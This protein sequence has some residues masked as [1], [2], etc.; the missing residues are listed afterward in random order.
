LA[1]SQ[2]SE[3]HAY[4][5]IK[6]NLDLLGW[7][8]RNPERSATGQ[9]WTQNEVTHN[10]E[11]RRYL[12]LNKPEN[13]VKV[14]DRVLWVIEAKR[15][16]SQL[17]QAVREAEDY[18]TTLRPSSQVQP[19]FVTG[20]AGNDIDSYLVRSEFWNGTQYVPIT[21]N[22][23]PAT[24]LLALAHLEQILRTGQGKSVIPRLTSGCSWPAPGTSTKSYTKGRLTRISVPA[25]W[26]RSSWRS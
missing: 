12:I 4:A 5:W 17:H 18:A 20:V 19:L 8:I 22:D 25:S 14:T 10:E 7:D 9:V 23:I 11:L 2:D 26:Q 3:V 24:G 15:S 21:L 1:R 6:K 13:I 16:H